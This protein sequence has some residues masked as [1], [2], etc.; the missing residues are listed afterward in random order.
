VL[1]SV[2]DA[3]ACGGGSNCCC[4]RLEVAAC[5]SGCCCCCYRCAAV[6]LIANWIFVPCVFCTLCCLTKASHV[7]DHPI[8]KK[9]KEKI[10]WNRYRYRRGETK[11]ICFGLINAGQICTAKC[12]NFLPA[13]SAAAAD[14]F[15]S[16]ALPPHNNT[17]SHTYTHTHTH[18]LRN[19]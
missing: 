11:A 17:L 14:S 6:W 5:Q 19:K 7:S 10:N 13:T 15:D 18:S 16:F 12:N 3:T 9:C 1:L 8:D 4:C 2:V